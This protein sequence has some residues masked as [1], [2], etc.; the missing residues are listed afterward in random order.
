MKYCD[1]CEDYYDGAYCPYCDYGKREIDSTR[2]FDEWDE[3]DDEEAVDLN[4]K[5]DG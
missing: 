4:L 3:E 2:K 1:R 5:E